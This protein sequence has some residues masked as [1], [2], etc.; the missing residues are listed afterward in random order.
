MRQETVNGG[1]AVLE[2]EIGLLDLTPTMFRCAAL[3]S[4]PAVLKDERGQNY[5]IIGRRLDPD[6]AGIRG[7]VAPHEVALE[8]SAELLEGALIALSAQL[9]D[10]ILSHIHSDDRAAIQSFL[11]CLQSQ[12]PAATSLSL[13][14]QTPIRKESVSAPAS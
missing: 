4:C 7:R 9:A 1:R 10:K 3:A 13:N 14:A 11:N 6:T 2:E 8:I 12:A 5:V